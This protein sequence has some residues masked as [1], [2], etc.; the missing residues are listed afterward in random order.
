MPRPASEFIA[1]DAPATFRAEPRRLAFVTSTPLC[2]A[3][4]SGTF[5]G[6]RELTR[7]LMRRGVSVE[8]YAPDFWCPSYTLKRLA[9]NL[10]VARRLRAGG[11]DWVV[12]F[13]LDGFYYGRRPTAPY[14]ASIKGVIAD[15]LRNERGLV[16]RLLALQARFE[17][18][19]VR[20][21]SVVVATSLY[22]RE[23]IV[24]A[25]GV[26]P[27]KVVLVP[28]PIDLPAW[29]AVAREGSEAEPPAVLSVAHMYPRKNLGLLVRA[30][31]RLKE[32]G[33]AFQA[34]LVGDGP[35]RADWERLRNRL[36]LQAEV[37]F[38]GSVPRRELEERYRRAAV[39][40]LPSRQEGFGI[41]FLEAMACGKPVVAARAAAVP[42]TVTDGEVGVL[43]DPADADALTGALGALLQD[44]GRRRTLGEAGRARAQ[45]YGADRVAQLFLMRVGAALGE[46]AGGRDPVQKEAA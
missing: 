35:C 11:H 20:R 43:V 29:S 15:E 39:F 28:E 34:W 23:R 5:V 24:E 2:V 38:L 36:G 44:P 4:G 9:F 37:Q 6:I 25:Y 12:G 22:S 21:A 30:C 46:A 42:E 27:R 7:S 17:R 10:R 26:L 32:A 3:G 33:V 13:D 18:L 41:V 14:V 1:A 16:R 40:C 8:T 19:A 31:A 45:G